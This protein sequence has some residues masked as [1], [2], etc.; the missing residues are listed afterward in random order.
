MVATPD[1]GVTKTGSPQRDFNYDSVSCI[2]YSHSNISPQSDTADSWSVF[3]MLFDNA[4][5]SSLSLNLTINAYCASPVLHPAPNT[6]YIDLIA[7]SQ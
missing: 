6:I 2:S 1:Y 7:I 4:D 3:D 5:L